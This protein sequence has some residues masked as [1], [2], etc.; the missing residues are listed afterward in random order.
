MEGIR[1]AKNMF[2]ASTEKGSG[3]S[4]ITIGLTGALQGIVPKVGFM[5]PI[6][7]RYESSKEIDEE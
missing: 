5:K 2:I 7:Q 6:G 4:L 3:K 1:M